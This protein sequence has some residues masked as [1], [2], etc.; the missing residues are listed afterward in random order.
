MVFCIFDVT[1]WN[2]MLQYT[3]IF[4]TSQLTF[5]YWNMKNSSYWYYCQKHAQSIH[6]MIVKIY[7]FPIRI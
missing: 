7:V 3:F 1:F 2:E 6:V 5:I 4:M